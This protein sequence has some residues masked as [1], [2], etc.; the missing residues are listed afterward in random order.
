LNL[1]KNF[2]DFLRI[3]YRKNLIGLRCVLTKYFP[4]IK[5]GQDKNR[6]DIKLGGSGAG[7]LA[8]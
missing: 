1:L 3:S 5:L 2:S 4:A 6:K 8:S 7:V